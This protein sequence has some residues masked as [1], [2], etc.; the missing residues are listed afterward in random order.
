MARAELYVEGLTEF[1]RALKDIDL[2][3]DLGKAHKRVSQYVADES[4]KT[5]QKMTGRFGVYRHLEGKIRPSAAKTAAQIRIPSPVAAGAEW[6]AKFHTVFGRKVP[7]SSMKRR[8]FPKWDQ[9]GYLVR[10]TI[11]EHQD[12]ILD[13][14]GDE[15][16]TLSRR[17]FP[18]RG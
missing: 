5:R 18:E 9:V 16:E 17:A 3:R 14:Y 2:D 4:E 12:E 1:R 6:G 10:P 15:I 13:R 7:A 11:Q 8:V